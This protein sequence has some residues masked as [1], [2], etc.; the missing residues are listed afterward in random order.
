MNKKQAE[1][2]PILATY[3][4]YLIRLWKDGAMGVWR[5]SAQSIPT[6]QIIR[7]AS[8]TELFD[9]LERQ[10]DESSQEKENLCYANSKQKNSS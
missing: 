9:Y 8:L 3:Q 10:T 1:Q 5:A 6:G 2:S 4:S 7:F